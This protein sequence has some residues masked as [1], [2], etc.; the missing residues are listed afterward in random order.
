MN[1]F[2]KYQIVKP[3]IIKELEKIE[4]R[5]PEFVDLD[6]P[7]SIR[8]M[9]DHFQCF[10]HTIISQQLSSAA[11]DSIWNKLVLNLKKI[12]YKTIINIPKEALASI[13]LSP[14]K[15]SLVKQLAY[16]IADKKLNLKKLNKKT[17]DEISLILK[18]YK[19][20]G[21]WTIDM[22]LIFTYY[23][24]DIL[25]TTDYGIISGI[26]KL[27][28]IDEV[29]PSFLI[30]LKHKLSKYATLFSFCMWTL[31]KTMKITK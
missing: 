20:V 19:Y 10:M 28:N 22:L 8:T 25:A 5:L 4:P 11:V 12:N 6:K 16:D 21:Q 9:P 24:N 18:Q 17:N 7:F 27:Y 14:Q 30:N 31:N 3:E 29:T 26:K 2:F 13:G 15:I 23:R 1:K